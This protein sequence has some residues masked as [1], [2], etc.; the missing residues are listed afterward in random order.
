MDSHTHTES[1]MS[2]L[3]PFFTHIK[4]S[5]ELA[6]LCHFNLVSTF[7]YTT[8]HLLKLSTFSYMYVNIL[9]F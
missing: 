7:N 3:F 5:M 2:I 4:S 9:H 6:L 1:L 8:L